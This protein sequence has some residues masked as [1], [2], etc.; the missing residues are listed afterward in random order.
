M[1]S[2]CIWSNE[3]TKEDFITMLIQSTQIIKQMEIIELLE[4]WKRASFIGDRSYQKQNISLIDGEELF[5]ISINCKVTVSGNTKAIDAHKFFQTRV[6]NGQG[7][8]VL[9]PKVDEYICNQIFIQL[10][11]DFLTK[12]NTFIDEEIGKITSP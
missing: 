10:E 11:N 9:N 6:Q 2:M 5:L 3:R 1:Q 4:K 7:K 8:E 12:Y